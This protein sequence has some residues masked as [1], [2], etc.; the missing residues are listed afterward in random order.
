VVIVAEKKVA[1]KLV[2]RSGFEKVNLVDKHV[3]CMVSGLVA[4]A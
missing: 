1:S 4:D 3:M 2:E